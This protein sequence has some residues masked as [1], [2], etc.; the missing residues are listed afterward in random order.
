LPSA[1]AFTLVLA[2]S[3]N[4]NIS[5]QSRTI[6]PAKSGNDKDYIEIPK[7]LIMIT[8]LLRRYNAYF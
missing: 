4:Q 7:C 1:A 2:C 5:V 6:E 8:A 3:L